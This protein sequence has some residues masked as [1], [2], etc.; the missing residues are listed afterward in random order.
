MEKTHTQN[1][2]LKTNTDD[3]FFYAF[4]NTYYFIYYSYV[5]LLYSNKFRES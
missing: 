3:E 1:Y 4:Q 5:L 2:D